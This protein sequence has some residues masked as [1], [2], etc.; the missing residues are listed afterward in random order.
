MTKKRTYRKKTG[1]PISL[2]AFSLLAKRGEAPLSDKRISEFL[3]G[4][5]ARL[6]QDQGATEETISASRLALTDRAVSVLGLIRMIEKDVAKFGVFLESGKFHPLLEEVYPRY[7]ALLKTLLRE[8][9]IEKRADG[10]D[11]LLSYVE[12]RYGKEKPETEEKGD[13]RAQ[14]DSGEATESGDGETGRGERES[15]R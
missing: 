12:E 10:E 9:G 7:V 6:L 11:D 3:S 5:R 4:W 13:S 14:D 2:G 1:R 8:I 15:V